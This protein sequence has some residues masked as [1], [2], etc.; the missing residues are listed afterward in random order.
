M[1]THPGMEHVFGAS[2]GPLSKG[3]GLNHAELVALQAAATDAGFDTQL[4]DLVEEGGLAPALKPT[5]EP[6]YVLVGVH[7]TPHGTAPL[8][9]HGRRSFPR[10]LLTGACCC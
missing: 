8:R 1:V 3:Q 5:A 10:P 9:P 2:G 7:R 4:V 6:A